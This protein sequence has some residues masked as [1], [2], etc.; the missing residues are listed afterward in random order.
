MSDKIKQVGIWAL[1]VGA[2]VYVFS[3]PILIWK[4]SNIGKVVFLAGTLAV[5]IH[6]TVKAVDKGLE[7]Y[8]TYKGIR[9]VAGENKKYAAAYADLESQV[10]KAKGDLSSVEALIGNSAENIRAKVSGTLQE[11]REEFKNKINEKDVEDRIK[12]I[13]SALAL[14]KEEER[15]ALKNRIIEVKE[16]VKI[17]NKS[18]DSVEIR[19]IL[20][21]IA[22]HTS[23]LNANEKDRLLADLK[24]IGFRI[25]KI[26]Q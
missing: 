26:Q 25:D 1:I 10:N 9:Y 18:I 12:E 4:S 15:Q 23:L 2:V 22:D 19:Q 17:H 16:L 5:S 3:L 24:E 6:F 8:Q 7:Y 13:E 20:E 21:T 11:A 14:M